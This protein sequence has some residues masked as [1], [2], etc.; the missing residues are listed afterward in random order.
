LMPSCANLAGEDSTARRRPQSPSTNM[1]ISYIQTVRREVMDIPILESLWFPSTAVPS[2]R[3]AFRRTLQDCRRQ[4]RCTG[5]TFRWQRFAKGGKQ[6]QNHGSG[7]ANVD[8]LVFD[9]QGNVWGVTDMST[10]AHN[11]FSTGAAATQR[12]IDHRVVGAVVEGATSDLNVE[13]SDLIGVL[14]I[15]GCSSFPPVA[16]MRM[17]T[18]CLWPTPLC[19]ATF[20]G[21][22]L[23]ISVQHP[24]EECP[25][26]PRVILNRILD[27]ELGWQS[28]YQTYCP[29]WQ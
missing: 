29:S 13:T 25:F 14:A 27:A 26:N 16:R 3:P 18:L 1:F 4:L 19:G 20:V 10:S 7:F 23:I 6:E 11:G 22:T 12:S 8:N 15:T 21:D 24:G 9:S 17:R 2:A 5:N 28:L